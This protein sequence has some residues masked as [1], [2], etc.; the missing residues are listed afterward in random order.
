MFDLSEEF[1]SHRTFWACVLQ[2]AA[3]VKAKRV[4]YHLHEGE[5][6]LQFL[7]S[8]DECYP[9]F[10]PP[11]EFREELLAAARRLA[12]GGRWW[13]WGRR[14]LASLVGR[15]PVGRILVQTPEGDRM[16]VV[17]ED[18]RAVTFEV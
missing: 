7:R 17:R 6:C 12:F 9:L 3:S 16:W 2:V 11:E 10:P 1:A 5:N 8:D 14:V 18:A 4:L 13:L 15:A